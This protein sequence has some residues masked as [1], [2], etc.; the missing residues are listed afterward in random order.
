MAR[1]IFS[2]SR[3]ISVRNCLAVAAGQ[4]LR[5]IAFPSISTGAYGYPLA[6]AA[7]IAVTTARDCLTAHPEIVLVRFVLFGQPAYRAYEAALT[8]LA[9]DAA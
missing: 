8:E 4:G 1:R 5:T 9:P 2:S 7:R 6:E 3:S